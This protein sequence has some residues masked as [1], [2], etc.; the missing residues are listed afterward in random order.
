M[1]RQSYCCC[2]LFSKNILSKL[3]TVSSHNSEWSYQKVEMNSYF[4]DYYLLPSAFLFLLTCVLICGLCFLTAA[5]ELLLC[6][7]CSVWCRRLP[8]H[9]CLC[10]PARGSNTWFVFLRKVSSGWHVNCIN[11]S[12]TTKNNMLFIDVSASRRKATKAFIRTD[13]RYRSS[14]CKCLSHT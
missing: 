1:V 12:N 8:Y 2:I 5:D 9:L 3:S 10:G 14:V 11:Y 13:F 6:S 7:Y 4:V